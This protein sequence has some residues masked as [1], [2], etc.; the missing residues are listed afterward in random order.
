MGGLGLYVFRREF[1]LAQ[2]KR[3]PAENRR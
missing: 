2:E 3:V 1:L